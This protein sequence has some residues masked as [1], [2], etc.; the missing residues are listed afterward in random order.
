MVRSS[1]SAI[2]LRAE[3][4]VHRKSTRDLT[5][6]ASRLRVDQTLHD[7][8]VTPLALELAVPLICADDP[9]AAARMKSQA[10]RVLGENARH[11]LPEA[12]LRVGPA[13]RLQGF[14]SSA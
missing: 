13:Q 7:D 12:T 3:L 14:L 9:E 5:M 4:C 8:A 11:D 10:C 1:P 6:S 2:W